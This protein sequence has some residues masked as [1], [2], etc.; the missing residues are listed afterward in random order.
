MLTFTLS[1]FLRNFSVA[2]NFHIVGIDSGGKAYLLYIDD[3]LVLLGFLF[4]LALLKLV[5]A[6]VHYLAYGR[7]GLRGYLDEVKPRFFGHAKSDVAMN[8]AL[9]VAVLVDKAHFL[10]ADLL[11]DLKFFL[12]YGGHLHIKN[13]A[14]LKTRRIH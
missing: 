9:L 11:V 4:P 1:P 5:L 10:I 2:F 13:S 14:G 12:G 8:N 6:V 7:R 3:L